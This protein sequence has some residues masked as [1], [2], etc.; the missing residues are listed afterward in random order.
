MHRITLVNSDYSEP[1]G[2][3]T[4]IKSS[5]LESGI[6]SAASSVCKTFEDNI[7]LLSQIKKIDV[8]GAEAILIEEVDN[9]ENS[10][11]I[12]IDVPIRVEPIVF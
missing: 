2:M 5:E 1:F 4:Y 3:E 10:I 12:L 6:C 7:N 9:K 8:K 11:L